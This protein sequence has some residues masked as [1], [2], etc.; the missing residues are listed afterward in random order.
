MLKANP[1]VIVSFL[2]ITITFRP[3]LDLPVTCK[4]IINVGY[5]S[6]K[7]ILD[8]LTKIKNYV[9]SKKSDILE[10]C[11]EVNKSKVVIK[12]LQGSVVTQTVLGGPT[13]YPLVANFV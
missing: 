1:Y 6:F 13:I 8:I 3:Q 10:Q 12:M 4:Y 11:I 2:T 9:Q 5:D 7:N